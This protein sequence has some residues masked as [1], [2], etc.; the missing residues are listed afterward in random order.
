M[1]NTRKSC[2]RC[3]RNKVYCRELCS[4]CY[5][6]DFY[7]KNKM[8]MLEKMRLYRE[9]NPELVQGRVNRWR[10]NNKDKVNVYHQRDLIKNY[11]RRRAGYKSVFLDSF[12]NAKARAGKISM[13]FSIT[14]QEFL[15]LVDESRGL[16]FYC[17]QQKTLGLDRC[18]NKNGYIR[19]NV[20]MTCH[21]C[22]TVKSDVFTK[23]EMLQIADKFLVI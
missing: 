14:K 4:S 8:R 22:N 16:C 10:T 15:A 9:K 7:A 13:E 11:E 18:D 17:K 3:Q 6:K 2:V 1:K 19:S 20:V 23:E 21:R 5:Y 12:Y